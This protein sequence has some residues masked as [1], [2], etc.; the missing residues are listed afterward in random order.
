M[1]P[2]SKYL[3]VYALAIALELLFPLT[4]GLALGIS[5]SLCDPG[6][7]ASTATCQVLSRVKEQELIRHRVDMI[8]SH[9]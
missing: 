2:T 5:I 1:A 7:C 6:P 8:F 4:S 9:I 3:R